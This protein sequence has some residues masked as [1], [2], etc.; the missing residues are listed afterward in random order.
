MNTKP[1]R[2]QADGAPSSHL[3]LTSNDARTLIP[4]DGQQLSGHVQTL[5]KSFVPVAPS[6]APIRARRLAPR[7][8]GPRRPRDRLHVAGDGPRPVRAGSGLALW[9][10]TGVSAEA[11]GSSVTSRV[12]SP[13]PLTRARWPAV[14]VMLDAGGADTYTQR[15]IPGPDLRLRSIAL[16]CAG[17]VCLD[18]AGLARDLLLAPALSAEA[19]VSHAVSRLW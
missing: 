5:G 12:R 18:F 7:H 10:L 14:T 13:G 19:K 9:F 8:P 17:S 2:P 6:V 16:R 1:R 11:P 15:A 3:T 4:N